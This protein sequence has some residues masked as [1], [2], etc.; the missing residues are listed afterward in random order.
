MLPYDSTMSPMDATFPSAP[1]LV[2]MD[3]GGHGIVDKRRGTVDFS[4]GAR[5]AR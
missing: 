2:V 5:S 4:P 1:E 3:C